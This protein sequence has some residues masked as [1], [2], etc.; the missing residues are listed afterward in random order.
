MTTVVPIRGSSSTASTVPA[1]AEST[2]V[3]AWAAMSMPSWV[4]QSSRVSLY[5]SWSTEKAE[6]TSPCRGETTRW[7]ASATTGTVS[8]T[9]TGSSGMATTGVC[10]SSGSSGSGMGSSSGRVWAGS[11]AG[12]ADS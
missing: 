11:A 7:G 1:L 12:A 8:S 6:T 3:P 10:T 4:R 9:V 2:W 5:V